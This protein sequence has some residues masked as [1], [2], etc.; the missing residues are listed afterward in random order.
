M[1]LRSQYSLAREGVTIDTLLSLIKAT[2]LNPIYTLP[3]Y[4]LSL[5]HARGLEIAAKHP[6]AATWIRTLAILGVLRKLSAFLDSGVTNNWTNDVYDW[7]K[8]VVVVTGGSDGIG[9]KVVQLLGERGIK[10]VVLDVQKL[11]YAGTLTL[12]IAPMVRCNTD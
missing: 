7:G 10:V 8:E 11:K 2:A 6:K 3:A 1:P 4:I 9:A 12:T 5:Y